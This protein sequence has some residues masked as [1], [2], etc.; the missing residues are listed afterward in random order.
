MR[1]SATGTRASSG[2]LAGGNGGWVV[3]PDSGAGRP[4]PDMFPCTATSPPP[5][6]A[7]QPSACWLPVW[8]W[9]PSGFRS[10]GLIRLGLGLGA[11]GD[12]SGAAGAAEFGAGAGR[13]G[14]GCQRCQ[15]PASRDPRGRFEV[16]SGSGSRGGVVAR[17]PP[18]RSLKWILC[19]HPYPPIR[20]LVCVLATAL[21][22]HTHTPR[23]P[24][25]GLFWEIYF[26]PGVPVCA[27]GSC[28]Y[29]R[30]FQVINYCRI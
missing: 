24:G 30:G 23:G 20:T 5:P 18:L 28:A 3:L 9:L 1:V 12:R 4:R 26:H 11:A 21:R 29:T 19:V 15:R 16:V 6:P 13:C 25:G 7:G 14:L 2:W 22:L 10:A 27:R 17:P 8:G